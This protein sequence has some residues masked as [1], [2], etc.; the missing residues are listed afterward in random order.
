MKRLRLQIRVNADMP[1]AA[2]ELLRCLAIQIESKVFAQDLGWGSHLGYK[3]EVDS[4]TPEYGTARSIV[5]IREMDPLELFH[6][7]QFMEGD[8]T[9]PWWDDFKIN[10]VSLAA[11][12]KV[13]EIS[14]KP[15]VGAWFMFDWG[16][17]HAASVS[18]FATDGDSWVPLLDSSYKGSIPCEPEVT[19]DIRQS[20]YLTTGDQ[21]VIKD[22][23]M[24]YVDKNFE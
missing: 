14:T 4:E 20:D 2:A 8:E 15:G 6:V 13:T 9:L 18:M 5:K 3:F 12:H 24:K 22:R 19:Y 1:Q 21:A 7:F 10:V 16:Y 11:N 17:N 23:I